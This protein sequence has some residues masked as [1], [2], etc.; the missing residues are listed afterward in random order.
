MV[1]STN[2]FLSAEEKRALTIV[3]IEDSIDGYA[4]G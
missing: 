4:L 2:Y 3:K 1:L